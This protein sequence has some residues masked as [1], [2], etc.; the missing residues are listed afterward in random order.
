M[1]TAKAATQLEWEAR[2][3]VLAEEHHLTGCARHIGETGT[4]AR[5]W[6]VRSQSSADGF[7]VV[8]FWEQT[9]GIVCDCVAGSYGRPC[10]H[11]GAALHGE[12][13]RER[14]M[15]SRTDEAMRS[16]M[17]GGAW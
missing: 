16:W 5:L 13:Q 14:A 2:A 7:H 17:N 11:A 15:S 8:T 9:R 3:I 4:G 10:S 1:A 12:R 6:K